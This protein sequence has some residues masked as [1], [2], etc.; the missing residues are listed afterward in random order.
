MPAGFHDWRQDSVTHKEGEISDRRAR[1]GNNPVIKV[2]RE[3]QLRYPGGTIFA[4]RYD[5]LSDGEQA[6]VF[7]SGLLRNAVQFM[8]EDALK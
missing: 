4:R 1:Q 6:S 8:V 7:R 5:P 2:T 3:G